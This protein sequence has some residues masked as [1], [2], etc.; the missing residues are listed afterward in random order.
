VRGAEAQD[1]AVQTE[2]EGDAGAHGTV[3]RSGSSAARN[4]I[5]GLHIAGIA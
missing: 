4:R 3:S 2:P 5:V 1:D